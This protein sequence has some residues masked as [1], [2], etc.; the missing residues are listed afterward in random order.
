MI[1]NFLV[2]VKFSCQVLGK[3]EISLKTRQSYSQ[4]TEKDFL[5]GK[6]LRLKIQAKGDSSKI[7][8]TREE[9]KSKT[10]TVPNGAAKAKNNNPPVRLTRAMLLRKNRALGIKTDPEKI[11]PVKGPV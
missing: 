9:R 5:E 3:L 1:P 4:F 2:F 10:G 11:E 6:I 8:L 7:V